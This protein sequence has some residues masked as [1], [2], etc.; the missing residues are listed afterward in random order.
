M[1]NGP[2]KNWLEP[3]QL[4]GESEFKFRCHK[5]I[6][7]FTKCCS[8]INTILTPYDILRMK[9]SLK[10][11]SEEFLQK[12]TLPKT[13]EHLGLPVITLKMADDED[14]SCPFLKP[15]GCTIYADRPAT[16]RYYP[17]GLAAMKEENIQ[18]KE[19]FY[20]FIHEDHCLGFQEDQEWT[21]HLW[22]SL[23]SP[24]RLLNCISWSVMIWTVSGDLSLK[25]PFWTNMKFPGILSKK[26]KR[27][28]LNCCFSDCAG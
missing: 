1:K 2:N 28:T 14:K 22:G 12:Y 20:F 15:D 24:K 26:L 21:V 17:V 9:Q 11:T 18:N 13:L 8:N 6:A 25:V 5:K 7:C 23:R 10:M 27:M 16:C 4:T 19:E 3:Q